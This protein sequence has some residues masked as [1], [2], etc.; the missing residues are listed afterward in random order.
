M[1]DKTRPTARPVNDVDDIQLL[2]IRLDSL[3]L[4][5]ARSTPDAAPSSTGEPR[6]LGRSPWIFRTTLSQHCPLPKLSMPAIFG[7]NRDRDRKMSILASQSSITSIIHPLH[8]SRTRSPMR[9]YQASPS[10]DVARGM[11]WGPIPSD[12]HVHTKVWASNSHGTTVVDDTRLGGRDCMGGV[13]I[14]RHISSSSEVSPPKP[15][16]V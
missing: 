3:D 2:N 13:K 1:R 8:P 5:T 4:A 6:S 9:G 15:A 12:G 14:E 11:T 7:R 16:Y 10:K